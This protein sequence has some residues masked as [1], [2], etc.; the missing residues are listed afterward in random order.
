MAK[1]RRKSAS[2]ETQN[3]ET[4]GDRVARLRKERGFTQAEL[5]ERAGIRQSHLS[6]LERGR[7]HLSAELAVRLAQSLDVSTDILLGLKATREGNRKLPRRVLR[8]IEQ[9]EQLP[10]QAQRTLLKTID[11]FLKGAAS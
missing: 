8:R 11:T 3:G 5:G 1:Q 6:D 2:M 7:L 10:P 9:I 4:F